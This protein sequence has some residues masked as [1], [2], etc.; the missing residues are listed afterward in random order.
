MKTKTLLIGLLATT[1][2]FSGCKKGCTD[3]AA[4][5]YDPEAKKN[6]N[7]CLYTGF[8]LFY[9]EADNGCGNKTVT[10]DGVNKGSITNFYTGALYPDCNGLIGLTVELAQGT[11][12][13][14]ITDNCSTWT[15]DFTI[16]S[17]ECTRTLLVI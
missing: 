17:D 5:N 9:F 2:L 8:E 10:V 14:T 12:T 1:L 6:D 16:T 11:Y 13:Y 15:N 7:T 3:R 4:T